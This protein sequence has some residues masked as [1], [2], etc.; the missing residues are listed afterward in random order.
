MLLLLLYHRRLCVVYGFFIRFIH[1]ISVCARLTIQLL[2]RRSYFR[3]FVHLCCWLLKSVPIAKLCSVHGKDSTCNR[4]FSH[5]IFFLL[6]SACSNRCC[7]CCFYFFVNLDVLKFFIPFFSLLKY[8]SSLTHTANRKVY[9][10]FSQFSASLSLLRLYLS[11]F[12]SVCLYKYVCVC[13]ETY[14]CAK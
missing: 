6:P 14:E 4:F 12:L 9:I 13:V 1:K 5:S 8:E 7:C 3:C 2:D 11:L 10:H